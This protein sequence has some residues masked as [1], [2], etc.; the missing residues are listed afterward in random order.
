MSEDTETMS[1]D[2]DPLDPEPSAGARREGDELQRMMAVAR[3]MRKESSERRILS[4]QRRVYRHDCA[5]T[6]VVAPWNAEG[7]P[8]LE[9]L[10]TIVVANLSRLGVGFIH[11]ERFDEPFLML[12]MK[13]A[14][15]KPTGFIATVRRIATLDEGFFYYGCE[16]VKRIPLGEATG[17]AD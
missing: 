7:R 5:K 10:G 14:G 17:A 13:Q 2:H 15:Q 9:R 8:V 4:E 16:F 11:T 6:A 12:T 1:F 3:R